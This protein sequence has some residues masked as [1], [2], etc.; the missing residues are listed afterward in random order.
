MLKMSLT[1]YQKL[2]REM[3]KQG[4]SEDQIGI[5]AKYGFD[6]E[7]MHGYEHSLIPLHDGQSGRWAH[8]LLRTNDSIAMGFRSIAPQAD[9]E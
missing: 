4:L 3:Q 9:F 5:P 7:T 8:Q 2:M 1:R 6:A